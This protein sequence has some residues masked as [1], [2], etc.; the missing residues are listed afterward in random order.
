MISVQEPC[1]LG[2]AEYTLTPPA[3]PLAKG[4]PRRRRRPELSRRKGWV[5]LGY[6]TKCYKKS[7]EEGCC[8]VHV[9]GMPSDGGVWRRQR[10][11]VIGVKW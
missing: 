10:N 1:L 11:S 6:L 8:R 4:V 5:G 9:V 7:L 2:G 3:P